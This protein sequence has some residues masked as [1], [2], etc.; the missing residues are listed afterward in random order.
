M[1][2]RSRRSGST[3]I[4]ALAIQQATGQ[5]TELADVL[6]RVVSTR[7]EL[8]TLRG[9]R[10]VRSDGHRIEGQAEVIER[11]LVTAQGQRAV[12]ALHTNESLTTEQTVALTRRAGVNAETAFQDE[13]A[14]QAAAQIFHATQAPTAAGHVARVQAHNV[15]ATG[16]VRLVVL[17]FNTSVNHTVQGHARLGIRTA[18]GHGGNGSCKQFHLHIDTFL[19]N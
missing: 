6:D 13:D 10:V 16:H 7:L 18:G 17:V 11:R 14:L 12:V 9:D 1:V 5:A 19:V 8:G 2:G 15:V 3:G 4:G